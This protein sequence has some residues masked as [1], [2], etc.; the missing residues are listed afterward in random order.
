MTK[1]FEDPRDP[2]ALAE[3]K[4]F[5]GAKPPSRAQQAAAFFREN[6]WLW[7]IVFLC[8]TVLVFAR[9]FR[10][11]PPPS[12][13]LGAPAPRDIRAPFDLQI[14]D[15]VATRQ[16]QDEARARVAPLYDWDS[17]QGESLVRKI[18][19]AFSSGR[20]VLDDYGRYVADPQR[21]TTE[22]KEAEERLLNALGD[23]LGS[24][25]SRFALRQFQAEGFSPRAEQLVEAL[26]AQVSAR[27]I[28]AD[29]ESL[30]RRPVIRIRDIRKPGAE[31]EQKNPASSEIVSLSTARRLPGVL[32]ES[33]VGLPQG[34]RGALEEYAR[35]LVQ[36]NLTFNSE[37]TARRQDAAAAQVEPLAVFVRKGQVILKAGE[38]VD[39][40]AKQKI[41]AFQTAS[42]AFVNLPLLLSLTLFVLLLLAFLFMYLKTYRKRY[43]P[44]LNLFVL[45]LQIMTIFLLVSQALLIALR[46]LAE[47]TR[48]PLLS[49]PELL[50]FLIPVASGAMLVTFLVDKHIAV[51]YS[52]VFSVL[53]G[54]LLDFNYPMMLYSML[55]CFTGIYAGYNLA[56]RAAQWKASLLLGAVNAL[57]AVAVLANDAV[58][59]H[60]SRALVPAGFAMASGVPLTAMLVSPL[61]P[62]FENAYGILTEVRLLE[63]SNM[64]HPLLRRLALDAP[65]T[66][67]HSVMMA[68]LSE[69]AANAI[70][71]NGL[72][73]RVSCYYHDI[74]KILNPVYF[75]ENQVPGQNPHDR[76]SPRIS[77]LIIAAHVKEG[78]AMARQYRLPR[79]VL[80]VI[81][82]HH[83]TRKIAFFYDK[84][85]TLHD[86][87]KGSINEGDY[88]YP[89]PKPLTREAAIIMLADGVE[90]GSRV[91]KEPS[92]QRLLALIEEITSRVVQEGQLDDCDITFKDL[93]K[94]QD[95]FLQILVG[96]FSRRI[97]YP[98][99]R[100]DKEDDSDS[101]GSVAS[102]AGDKASDQD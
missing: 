5:R 10:L 53:F 16:R 84:A 99:Y 38:K 21:T 92:H 83:G 70:G 19:A 96:V 89:G 30:D 87:E 45:V 69:A 59:D 37:E 79:A 82:Q 35:S 75:V 44:E 6:S 43:T 23:L 50:Y 4:A 100:F 48:Q 41:D 52:V 93:A 8:A 71:A 74:G 25:L 64:N 91:L 88:Q 56:Q 7:A 18:S 85:L 28:V 1:P 78:L 39:D 97:S 20:T 36:P 40:S 2:K 94:V 65:G 72:F 55:S 86:P 26:V 14:R 27:R 61:V 49:R 68:T 3:R 66:Y 81:P 102:R 17:A 11:Q 62:L 42:Q 58:W 63:L 80:D 29:Q 67:N 47:T 24:G 22:K 54:V 15:E 51:V 57:L 73:C 98:G 76:L 90:A 60:P 13:A 77:S 34:E 9:H 33:A 46:S 31:W 32:M 101:E 12:L 95:A